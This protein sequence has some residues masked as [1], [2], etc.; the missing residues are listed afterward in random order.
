MQTKLNPYINFKN[1]T[2]EA[3]NFYQSILAAS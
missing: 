3:M 1:S 2:S